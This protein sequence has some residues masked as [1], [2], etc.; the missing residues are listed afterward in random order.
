MK[1]QLPLTLGSWYSRNTKFFD[2]YIFR[3]FI[4]NDPIQAARFENYLDIFRVFK[5]ADPI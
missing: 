5:L 2:I 3:V 1:V 4:E